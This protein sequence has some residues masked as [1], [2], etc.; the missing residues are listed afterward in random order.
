MGRGPRGGGRTCGGGRA[1]LPC[2]LILLVEP[3]RTYASPGRGMLAGARNADA[4]ELMPDARRL[5]GE[6]WE[7]EG[8]RAAA[9]E[10]SGREETTLVVVVVAVAVAVVER[11]AGLVDLEPTSE[12]VNASLVA[13]ECDSA[14]A[15]AGCSTE[16]EAES[17]GS[18][19]GDGQATLALWFDSSS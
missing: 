3:R 18:C 1:A 14:E 6:G 16:G 13:I 10:P 4:R 9:M 15:C 7:K 11:V 12:P 5:L 2:E 8:A 17:T 19:G